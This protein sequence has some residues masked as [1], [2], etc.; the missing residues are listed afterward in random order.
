[1][2]GW[3][4]KAAARTLVTNEQNRGTGRPVVGFT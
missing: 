2:W 3:G 4:T 1:M